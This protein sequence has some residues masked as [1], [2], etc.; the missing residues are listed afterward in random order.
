MRYRIGSKTKVLQ[1]FELWVSTFYVEHSKIWLFDFF[2]R[3]CL[4]QW[5]LNSV[6][7]TVSHAPSYMVSLKFLHHAFQ[8]RKVPFWVVFLWGSLWHRAFPE[9]VLCFRVRI[10]IKMRIRAR[11]RVRVSGNT[12]KYV[13]G[14]LSIRTS[15][16]DPR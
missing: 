1:I 11:V 12:F 4:S 7:S 13:F 8:Y 15:V 14:Q 6:R 5:A 10:R 2:G 16:L 3:K 9:K